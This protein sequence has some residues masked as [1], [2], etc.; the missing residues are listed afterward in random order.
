MPPSTVL[1]LSGG[2][3]AERAVSLMSGAAVAEALRRIDRFRVVSEVIDRPTADRLRPLIEREKVDV[4]FPVL[5]GRWG[6]GG[7]LQEILEDLGRAYV[8]SRPRPAALAMDK[9]TTKTLLA[10]DD[11]PTP[12][13]RPL[14]P[15]DDCDL[16]P[17]LVIKPIDDGSSVDLRICRTKEQIAAARAELHPRRER[18]MAERYIA[19]RELTVGIVCGEALPL[20]E[21]I[22]SDAVEFYDYQA[23]YERDDTRYIVEPEVPAEID[24]R[25]RELALLAFRRLGCRDLARVDFMLDARGP[26]LLEVNTMPGFTSH[27]LVPLA[28]RHTGVDMSALCAT[29]VDAAAARGA[30]LDAAST[31]AAYLSGGR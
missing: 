29:L 5:H 2:P 27:S 4:I 25:C 16:G 20:I 21:I 8:G 6:E 23:K 22:P 3:D 14:R 11:V 19:G 12:P 15:E 17:P 9:L 28:A 30:A 7:A 24:L 1:I 31:T 10:D 13:A 18:L 26:W